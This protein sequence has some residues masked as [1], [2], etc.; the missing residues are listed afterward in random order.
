M[1]ALPLRRHVHSVGA[2]MV[3][4]VAGAAFG[5]ELAALDLAPSFELRKNRFV[6]PADRM[7]QHVEPARCAIP[8]TTSRAPAA[9]ACSMVWSSIGTSMSTPSMEKRFWPR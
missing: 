6:G 4:H 7:G 2:V 1:I 5:R 8:S 3:L 9:A